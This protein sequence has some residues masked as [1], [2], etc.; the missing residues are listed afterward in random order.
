MEQEA[1]R[2]EAAGVKARVWKALWLLGVW[3]V[4]G[5][6]APVSVWGAAHREV[7]VLAIDGPIVPVMV[8][9]VE[10]GLRVAE[11]RGSQAVVIQVNTPGGTL[12]AMQQ[13]IER[14]RNSPVPVV[15]YV[16]PRGARA[17]SAGALIV[18]AAHVAA[19]APETTLGGDAPARPQGEMDEVLR[20]KAVNLLQALARSL[21]EHRGPE[22]VDVAQ[23]IIAEAHALSV[24]EALEV[25]LVDFRARDLEH[26]L[27][28]MDGM[29]VETVQG[30]Q[31]LQTRGAYPY[32]VPRTLLEEALLVLTN[33][34]V[35]FL[36]LVLGVQFILAEISSPGGW[37]AGFL[38]VVFLGLA[39]YGLG[40]LPVNWF[41]L[42]LILAAAVLIALEVQTPGFQGG[43]ALAGAAS[44]IIG[45]LLLFNTPQALPFQRVSVPLVV[46]TGVSAT[47]LALWLLRLVV[48]A[49]R[50]P[51]VMGPER[52][53]DLVGA[54]GLVRTPITPAEPGTV[55]VRGELWTAEPEPPF[56]HIPRDTWVE[57]VRVQ[58]SR[59]F[60]R[61]VEAEAR[62]SPKAE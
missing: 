61:P 22:A 26:L 37:L 24:D 47:G 3:V 21:V 39:L 34:N 13:I 11:R 16:A 58:G 2:E 7:V 8:R 23:R 9:Y 15:A 35:I 30:P 6:Q 48:R 38:G 29:Q 43:L 14:L 45:A 56:T 32:E 36:L 60:V 62:P 28:Q 41:G 12:D 46:L 53:H 50:Q 27:E 51:V 20:A 57:V 54:R 17:A 44:F 59:V 40:A 10:R 31:V 33:P 55:Q 1:L 42:L 5:L 25:G 18:M 19:M 52:L 49:Q 4:L